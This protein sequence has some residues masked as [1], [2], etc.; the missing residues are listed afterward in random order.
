MQERKQQLVRAFQGADT[1]QDGNIDSKELQTFL[2]KQCQKNGE[3][4]FS[5]EIFQILLKKLDKN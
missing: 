2:D 3:A 1:N 4:E 5:H